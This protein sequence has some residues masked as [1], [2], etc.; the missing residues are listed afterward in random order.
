MRKILNLLLIA[1]SSFLIISCG[2]NNEGPFE[3]RKEDGNLVL[4]SNNKLAKGWVEVTYTDFNS[5]ITYKFS[6][7]EYDKGVPTGKFKYYNKNGELFFDANLTRKGELFKGTITYGVG[8]DT[9]LK[10]EFNINPNW[11]VSKEN[12]VEKLNIGEFAKATLYNGNIDGPLYKFGY[13]NGKLDNECKTY[14]KNGQVL[15]QCYYIDGEK[16]GREEWYDEQG[17]LEFLATYKNGILDGEAIEKAKDLGPTYRDIMRTIVDRVY[18]IDYMKG[19]YKSGK[20]IGVWE[21]YEGDL[22]VAKISHKDGVVDGDVEVYDE[23]SKSIRKAYYKNGKPDGVWEKYDS[24][25]NLLEKGQYKDG[26]LDGIW[27]Y[28]Q[29][30]NLVGQE[31]EYKNGKKTGIWKSYHYKDTKIS[32]IEYYK[33]GELDGIYEEYYKNGNLKEKGQY[34]NNKK[35]GDW[36]KYYED[37]RLEAEITYI[38]GE[39]ERAL[40]Y[41]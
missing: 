34:K 14:Y 9:I 21:I 40:D 16:D 29:V 31:G 37:G 1:V 36:K 5:N 10:G 27:K 28:Y 19:E 33:N 23:I 25:G 11:I 3:T 30:D 7:I 39:I 41:R 18:R 17:N 22:M 2:D 15:Y 32:K 26:E 13:K 20:R 35:E 8:H 38:D 24:D 12:N 6:E 4:Y